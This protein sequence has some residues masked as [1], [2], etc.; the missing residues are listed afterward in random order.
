MAAM[1]RMT[2]VSVTT[3]PTTNLLARFYRLNLLPVIVPRISRC[4]GSVWFARRAAKIWKNGLLLNLT[5][6]QRGEIVGYGFFFVESHLAGVGADETLIED[7]PGKLIKVFV[8]ERAQHARADFRGL[9]DG[10]ER[11]SALLTLLAKFFSKR[12]QRPAPAGGVTFPSASRW[13]NHRRSLGRKPE[14]AAQ[15]TLPWGVKEN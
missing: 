3:L 12:S 7:S 8:L 2:I 13:N 15:T 6:A 11:D 4:R 1:V 14:A 9:G 10:V 5:L